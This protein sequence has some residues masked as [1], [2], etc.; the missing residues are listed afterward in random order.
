MVDK[1]IL[2]L[3]SD[4]IGPETMRENI[5]VLDAVAMKYGHKFTYTHAAFGAEDYWRV[6]SCFP[7]ETR[8]MIKSG[9]FEGILK[10]PIGLD[11]EGSKKLRAAGV[12]LENE[13]V[14]ALRSSEILNTWAC[15]RPVVLPPEF[16]FFSPLRPEVAGTGIDILMMREL[17]GGIYFGPK[18]EGVD[19]DGRISNFA[20]DDCTYT[21]EQTERFARL[22]FTEA[23]KINGKL[24]IAHKNNVLAIGRYWK[25][26]FDEEAK[27]HPNVPYEESLIDSFFTNVTL[28]PSSFNGVVAFNN[29]DGDYTTDD[30]GGILGSLGLMP[31]AC[32]NPDTLRG[33]FEPSHG[34]APTIANQNK[35]NPYSMIGSGAFML[36]MAFGMK[37]ESQ[38]VWK[39]MK[40]VFA[41]GYMTGELVRRLN[42]AQRSA[43]ANDD[44]R[45]LYPAF[46][47]LRPEIS[48]ED[49]KALIIG[50]NASC[51]AG[52]EARVVSTSEFGDLV[53]KNIF[54][55]K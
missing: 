22:C 49:A 20:Q 26:I 3:N 14:I 12:K 41:Q 7:E 44:L 16:A 6:G 17:V 25:A 1:E 55:A 33:Y 52:L 45:R 9:Q 36:D 11:P 15:Y 13:T 40:A 34:S 8:A 2:I 18:K 51:D 19:K 37:E 50:A 23:E 42:D 53:V 54:G 28:R 30:A 32:W 39:S 47:L 10:G 38:D 29:L 43:R 27:K 4:G 46:K 24:T 48:K 31:S 5:K 21:Y 35:A